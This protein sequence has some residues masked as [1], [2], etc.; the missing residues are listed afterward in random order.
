MIS[1]RYNI[2]ISPI[3]QGEKLPNLCVNRHEYTDV[4][5]YHVK[6]Q[7]TRR[8]IHIFAKSN[9][10]LAQGSKVNDGYFNCRCADPDS[11]LQRNTRES[12]QKAKNKHP[13]EGTQNTAM[14]SLPYNKPVRANSNNQY[15]L[16]FLPPSSHILTCADFFS[17]SKATMSTAR[18]F[19]STIRQRRSTGKPYVS[20]IS[21]AMSPRHR[22]K[23]LLGTQVRRVS[24][25]QQSQ[26]PL[27]CSQLR[28]L[29]I[30]LKMTMLKKVM[31]LK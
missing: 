1:R 30:P 13:R 28:N 19:S 7:Q 14:W 4:F 27:L 20:Y 31:Y 6:Q 8:E 25:K 9:K 18:P 29:D 26:S 11:D 12:W 2:P 22:V 23:E 5:D 16:K 3:C 17:S 24:L 15:I 21:Q 10:G